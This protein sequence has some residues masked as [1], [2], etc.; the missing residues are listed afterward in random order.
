[1]NETITM[2]TPTSIDRS[3]AVAFLRALADRIE[4]EEDQQRPA[5]RLKLDTAQVEI[6]QEL[7]DPIEID[8]FPTQRIV[9][10]H[11]GEAMTLRLHWGLA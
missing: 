8:A 5:P 4:A 10:R 2:P 1:M 7:L 6:H 3:H 9:Q 11:V